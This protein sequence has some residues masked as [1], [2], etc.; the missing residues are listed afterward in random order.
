M[1]FSKSLKAEDQLIT[2]SF[3]SPS[4]MDLGTYFREEM[5]NNEGM[6]SVTR[7]IGN[8]GAER[9]KTISLDQFCQDRSID[10]ADLLKLD[11]QGHEY[12]ALKG[13]EV[14]IRGG[15]VGRIFMEL[16]WAGRTGAPCA[17]TESIRLL[18]R[19]D[20]LFSRPGKILDWEKT[21]DWLQGLSNV[22][23]RRP[24]S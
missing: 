22:V 1:R 24:H 23:A 8:S 21:G 2:M 3:I 4:T 9:V 17:A 19:A 20:Y 10:Q 14:L 5:G 15:R 18:E 11:V 6:N 12:T 16:N 13:A 7:D